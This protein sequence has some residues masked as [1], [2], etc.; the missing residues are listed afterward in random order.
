MA[1]IAMAR[2]RQE[3][4][5][6]RLLLLALAAGAL[7]LITKNNASASTGSAE[8][9]VDD[10]QGVTPIFVF[11]GGNVAPGKAVQPKLLVRNDTDQSMPLTISVQVRSARLKEWVYVGNGISVV[12]PPQD[13]AQ[14]VVP[15]FAIADDPR[16]R[17]SWALRAV[18]WDSDGKVAGMTTVESYIV[19]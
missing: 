19:V 13:T 18:A 5:G 16:Y 6:S 11:G 10:R 3:Q 2:P 17:G 14:V 15:P 1:A 4:G 9:M 12:V 7:W 8:S